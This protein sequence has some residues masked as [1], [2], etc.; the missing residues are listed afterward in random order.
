MPDDLEQRM[1]A[2]ERCIGE[3][4]VA[5]AEGILAEEFA[6]VFAH[7]AAAV[8]PRQAWLTVLPDYIVHSNDIEA[9]TIDIDGDWAA[10]LHVHRMNATVQGQD[11][12]GLFVI[13]DVW[14]RR[15][16]TWRLWRRHSTPLTAGSLVDASG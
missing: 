4:D 6:L 12:S 2:L 11:R 8:V 5:A 1:D 14:R 7:P 10:V 9:Q 16:G 15:D 13:S 3:R